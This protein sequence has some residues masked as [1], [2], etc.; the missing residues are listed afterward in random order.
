MNRTP[1]IIALCGKGGVGKTSLSAL[2]VRALCHD[3]GKR[4]LAI[5]ADPAVGLSYP[6]GVSVRKTVDQIR[7]DLIKTLENG[8][9]TSKEE[10]VRQLDYEMFSAIE[11]KDNLAF[12]AIGRP[13][14]DGC[15]CQVNSLLRDLIREIAGRFDAVVIDGE[16]GL[17]QIN[18]RVMDMVTHLVIAT[19][20]SLKGRNVAKTIHTL[21]SNMGMV[22]KAGVLFNNIRDTEEA[23]SVTSANT[24]PMIHLMHENYLIRRYDRE[25]LNFFTLPDDE[26][27]S[28]LEA[29]V[30]AFIS[31]P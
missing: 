23:D 27:L 4:I 25:G 18:R 13:E 1:I 31:E 21:S 17:E 19:D 16:A 26:G 24:L 22:R 10:L 9:K 2:I 28:R 14:G 3:R 8:G 11:E 29:S 7:N 30:M 12:L 15:Y 5:D 20:G 6:L